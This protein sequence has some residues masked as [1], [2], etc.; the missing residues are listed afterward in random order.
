MLF[1]LFLYAITIIVA[2]HNHNKIEAKVLATIE[3][4]IVVGLNSKRIA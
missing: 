1:C 2:I 4:L 3:F